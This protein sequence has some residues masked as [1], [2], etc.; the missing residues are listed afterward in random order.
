MYLEYKDADKTDLDG[1]IIF[2]HEEQ[3]FLKGNNGQRKG[4]S[5]LYSFL[6]SYRE[7]MQ[8]NK[9][10]KWNLFCK[11]DVYRKAR[12]SQWRV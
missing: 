2:E 3:P 1:Q 7:P 4:H 5:K 8:K 6:I 12:S 9:I 10:L 11:T